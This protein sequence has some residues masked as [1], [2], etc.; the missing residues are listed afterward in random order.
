M[1]E[2]VVEWNYIPSM[3][4]MIVIIIINII[5]LIIGLKKDLDILVLCCI[6]IIGI[7]MLFSLPISKLIATDY[8]K[9]EALKRL[10]PIWL[11]CV[12]NKKVSDVPAQSTYIDG[13]YIKIRLFNDEIYNVPFIQIDKKGYKR[14]VIPK[15]YKS[16]RPYEKYRRAITPI[17]V[18]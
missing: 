16:I 2:F 1:N 11:E 14:K 3:H 7:C 12:K 8:M 9:R 4:I 17:K 13:D 6:S 10:N 5:G 18:P 15:F